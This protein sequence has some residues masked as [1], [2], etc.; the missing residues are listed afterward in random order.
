VHA[1]VNNVAAD[2][3]VD[4]ERLRAELILEMRRAGYRASD[5]LQ[6]IADYFARE[7]AERG[8]A[9]TAVLLALFLARLRCRPAAAV[10]P[11]EIVARA[12]APRCGGEAPAGIFPPVPH[13]A[14]AWATFS[15][16]TLPEPNAMAKVNELLNY[17]TTQACER[18]LTRIGGIVGVRRARKES[19]REFSFR[20]SVA[21]QEEIC[22]REREIADRE[23]LLALVLNLASFPQL[24]P[25]E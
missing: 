12:D 15:K 4:C 17:A 1:T 18:E 19:S 11:G 8:P 5:L 13:R 24:Q 16:R 3:R 22:A 21:L 23:T 14:P 7:L 6:A 10:M 9:P 25:M 20:V 2:P